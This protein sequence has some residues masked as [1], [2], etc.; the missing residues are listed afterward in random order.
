MK[1]ALL[2]LLLLAFFE[3]LAMM[4][5]ETLTVYDGTDKNMYVPVYGSWA[6]AYLKCE[7]VVPAAVLEDMEGGTISQMD[8]YLSTPAQEAWTG[9]F[10]VFLK[11]VE[12]TALSAW[13]GT[14]NATTVFTGNLDGTGST[15]TVEFSDT[16]T[17]GGGNLLVGVYQTAKG[18][19]K[20][21]YFY[22]TTA[23]GASGSNYNS[24]SLDGVSFSQR[25]FLPKTTFTYT[26]ASVTCEKPESIEATNV[27]AYDATL[28][29]TGG[30]GEYNLQYKSPDDDWTDL[31]YE[32]S[33]T[34]YSFSGHNKTLDPN[35]TYSFRVQ[36]YCGIDPETEGEI[37]SGWRTID[38]TTDN[39]CATPTN[40]QIT[41]VTAESATLTWTPGYQETTWTV[42][43][44]KSTETEYTTETVN[45]TPT[46]T[47]GSL[48]SLTTYN[49][50][51]YNCENFVLGNFT[52]AAGIP[53]VEEFASAPYCFDRDNRRPAGFH[54]MRH[55]IKTN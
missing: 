44:K 46:L 48:S 7:F 3:P 2:I 14:D 29:W 26:A 43:Y 19:Y 49:V 1:K 39:P 35:T 23:T 52:T 51:V 34:S 27:T 41:D 10:Q 17:Y 22:G 4:G 54:L 15:M 25:N 45:G 47:L 40:L 12:E 53:L 21:C 20:S 5:Q 18:N 28:T 36:S 13:S 38:F 6:D 24:S 37:L 32:V 33:F 42:K 31:A 11:E 8:F 30:S 16:Y 50:Q 55:S 9:T